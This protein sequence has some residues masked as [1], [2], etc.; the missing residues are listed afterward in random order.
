[1]GS[2]FLLMLR[3]LFFFFQSTIDSVFTLY[4]LYAINCNYYIIRFSG[5]CVCG[6]WDTDSNTYKSQLKTL[7]FHH[8]PHNE[9]LRPWSERLLFAAFHSVDKIQQ[10]N[11]KKTRDV[12]SGHWKLRYKAKHFLTYFTAKDVFIPF[13]ILEKSVFIALHVCS[14]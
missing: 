7:T 10:W 9:E 12:R 8:L 11:K 6:Q 14:N 2:Y 13:Y 5:L 3:V 4:Y 1:M